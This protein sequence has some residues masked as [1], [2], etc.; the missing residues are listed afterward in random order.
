VAEQNSNLTLIAGIFA[1]IGAS[2][3]CAG[4]LVLLL[5]GVSGSW[6]SNLTALEPFRPLFIIAVLI[7]F[8]FSGWKMYRPVEECIPGTACAIPQVRTRRQII[9]WLAAASALVF[10][11][12]SYWLTWLI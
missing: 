4:P 10:I 7:L 6:I 11:T 2:L 8:G 3:C 5:L 12:S 9:F 1:A